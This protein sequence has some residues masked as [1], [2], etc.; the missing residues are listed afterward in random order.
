MNPPKIS[1]DAAPDVW[2]IR[3][4]LIS[5]AQTYSG[6]KWTDF[7][8]HDPGVM[9]L[10][11]IAYAITEIE[12]RASLDLATRL[13][14]PD[15]LI[16][17]NRMRLAPPP[18]VLR[19]QPVTISDLESVLSGSDPSVARV[20]ARPIC[21]AEA[22]LYKLYVVP[23]S[24]LLA[25]KACQ[26]VKRAYYLIRN[27]CEDLASV[28]AASP[29][30]CT[31][32]IRLEHRRR[33]VPEKI[34]AEV[35]A[36]CNALL[37]STADSTVQAS[38]DSASETAVGI[39]SE[40]TTADAFDNPV[41]LTSGWRASS[42]NTQL[43]TL[44]SNAVSNIPGVVHVHELLLHKI[45]KDDNY[46]NF[47]VENNDGEYLALE[48]PDDTDAIELT[49]RGL[50]VSLDLN[51]IKKMLSQITDSTASTKTTSPR[52]NITPTETREPIHTYRLPISQ[53]LPS[54]FHT[55]SAS[56]STR[57]ASKKSNNSRQFLEYVSLIDAML[58]ET[59]GGR[60]ACND[61]YSESLAAHRTYMDRD[62]TEYSTP[63]NRVSSTAL[64]PVNDRMSR[65]LDRLLAMYG[66]FFTQHS[67]QHFNETT[68]LEDREEQRL[69]N[70]RRLL[71]AL[72]GIEPQRGARYGF[73]KKL[74]ILLGIPEHNQTTLTHAL[75]ELGL[76]L[77][78]EEPKFPNVNI[79][80]S[81]LV[82]EP[83]QTTSG[84]WPKNAFA[85][86]IISET[87]LLSAAKLS[88]YRIVEHS[89][90]WNLNLQV[91][92]WDTHIRFIDS[93]DTYYQAE[94]AANSIAIAFSSCLEKAARDVSPTF[95]VVEDIL[96]RGTGA[97]DALTLDVVFNSDI[98]RD[99]TPGYRQF[100]NETVSLVCP[101]HILPR[102]HWKT[103]PEF[104]ALTNVMSAWN[105]EPH[106]DHA[107]DVRRLIHGNSL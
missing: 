54:S 66:E 95:L 105:A 84:N 67:L 4:A 80:S 53:E 55:K 52:L 58:D 16:D 40:I 2:S 77:L 94:E 8:I 37:N 36:A 69:Q 10:E 87:T 45:G 12:Y 31:L 102:L 28:E 38:T 23:S 19:M 46:E 90:Q 101:A 89:S 26:S 51:R 61:L 99:N 56:T 48:L 86:N 49:S 74:K 43:N 27:L 41:Q 20:T 22:G 70:K 79:P 33:A 100:V 93:F 83:T 62:R 60:Q 103:A 91:E 1:H 17:M 75:I 68:N 34:V 25:N 6:N 106:S 18:T 82:P 50:H 14:G 44:L 81:A 30:R 57:I 78:P 98:D 107:N 39:T 73:E 85:N 96:L 71:R 104:K 76:T 47:Q 42:K 13:S 59:E 64:D 72:P 35:F 24:P 5:N 92:D 3:E 32:T 88:S 97:F 65:A 7:N 11:Q 29:I 63:D 15:G 9:L 21:G